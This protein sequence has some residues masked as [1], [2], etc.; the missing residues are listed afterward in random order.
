MGEKQSALL[1]LYFDSE[2]GDSVF[3]RSIDEDLAE[4]MTSHSERL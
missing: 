2:D 4:Y 3:L 1:G